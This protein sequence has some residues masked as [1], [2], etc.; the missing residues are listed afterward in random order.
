VEPRRSTL[1]S[2]GPGMTLAS[3]PVL[4]AASH[5]LDDPT[6]VVHGCL[7]PVAAIGFCASHARQ[8]TGMDVHALLRLLP[9]QT[10]TL[11]E[12]RPHPQNLSPSPSPVPTG[13]HVCLCDCADISRRQTEVL[14]HIQKELNTESSTARV[15]DKIFDAAYT[16]ISCDRITFFLVDHVRQ[17]LVG[18][19]SKDQAEIL[20]MPWSR[21]LAGH[22][23]NTKEKIRLNNLY[24]DPRFDPLIGASFFVL[25][26]VCVCVCVCVCFF[27]F[28]FFISFSSFLLSLSLSLSFLPF[29]LPSLLP[30][31][32][33]FPSLSRFYMP[34]TRMHNIF[35]KRCPKRPC[36]VTDKH[37]GY[38]T[39][40][41]MVVPVLNHEGQ[42]IAVIQ[43]INK[44]G[45]EFNAEDESLLDSMG[46]A[47]GVALHKAQ[48]RGHC[49]ADG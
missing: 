25:L 7:E 34:L 18:R 42:C 23:Y 1:V 30:S 20:R 9:S 38:K 49:D 48:V 14:L 29:F 31:L 26:C 15:I 24:T 5:R 8:Y 47:A 28:F 39:Q 43:A 3:T 17:E 22:A 41:M 13:E 4:E 32:L 36:R 2:R 33:L 45:G 40:T 16:L 37:T 46:S 11:S 10:M 44:I 19:V 21:G 27:F 35:T 6:C 12:D